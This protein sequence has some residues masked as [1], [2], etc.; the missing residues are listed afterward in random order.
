MIMRSLWRLERINEVLWAADTTAG[1]VWAVCSN[2][3]LEA[4][5]VAGVLFE[6]LLR[7]L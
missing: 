4:G 3:A 7:F 6:I 1:W 5:L 2:N